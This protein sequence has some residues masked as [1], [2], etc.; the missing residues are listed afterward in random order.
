[1]ELLHYK[2]S[3]SE[4]QL[5][6]KENKKNQPPNSKKDKADSCPTR[7][8]LWPVA[9]IGLSCH[10]AAQR[11][12]YRR[13]LPGAPQTKRRRAP[14]RY[15]RLD[16]FIKVIRLLCLTLQTLPSKSE[17]NTSS[18]SLMKLSR[19]EAAVCYLSA[20][21]R[22]PEKKILKETT[23]RQELRLASGG[24]W[25]F[26]SSF[27]QRRHREFLIAAQQPQLTDRPKTRRRRAPRSK[28]AVVC[29]VVSVESVNRSVRSS[30]PRNSYDRRAR[31]ALWRSSVLFLGDDRIGGQQ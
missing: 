7:A 9:D 21:H 6:D 24:L 31:D 25:V 27:Q 22:I 28:N 5:H 12:P 17:V 29:E 2:S 18:R 23:D 20:A 30:P 16:L 15:Q 8:R 4:I 26:V 14:G 10:V 11:I 13:P 3:L 19:R 1:M